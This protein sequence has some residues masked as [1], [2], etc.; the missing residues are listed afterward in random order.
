MFCL[1]TCIYAIVCAYLEPLACLRVGMDVLER[2]NEESRMAD[3]R[4][5]HSCGRAFE[6]R[7][8]MGPSPCTTAWIV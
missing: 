2:F 6:Y 7:I 1:G 5:M 8:L 3:E 4:R